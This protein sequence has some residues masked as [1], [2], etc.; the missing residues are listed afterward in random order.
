MVLEPFKRWLL[1]NWVHDKLMK[2][3]K[4]V[5]ESEVWQEPRFFKYKRWVLPRV[6][7][8]PPPF[9]S[10]KSGVPTLCEYIHTPWDIIK[11][12]KWG[13]TP[14]RNNECLRDFKMNS[15]TL[16]WLNE[17]IQS[18]R[19]SYYVYLNLCKCIYRTCSEPSSFETFSNTVMLCKKINIKELRECG[20]LNEPHSYFCCRSLSVMPFI[21]LIGLCRSNMRERERALGLSDYF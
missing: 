2:A 15:M 5:F 14:F 20:D 1:K 11:Y 18:F 9:V 4:M 17:L 6:K 13:K 7:H 16:I 19:Q 8:L 12:Q 3:P 10:P 21:G